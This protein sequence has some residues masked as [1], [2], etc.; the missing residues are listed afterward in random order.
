MVAATS[1]R[2]S[3]PRHPSP[4]ELLK[5]ARELIL[6][7]YYTQSVA[8]CRNALESAV[9][10]L[11]IKHDIQTPPCGL[12]R[13][14]QAVAKFLGYSKTKRK[15]LR[16][17]VMLLNSGAHGIPASAGDAAHCIFATEPLIE[18]AERKGVRQ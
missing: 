4:A 1:S 8:T 13:W 18:A 16:L 14:T 15:S 3:Y 6:L 17:V 2:F 9:C 12:H 11:C 10:E 5:Q 7:G